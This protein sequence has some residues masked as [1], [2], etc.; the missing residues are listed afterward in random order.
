MLR[1]NCEISIY[2]VPE[3]STSVEKIII[4]N[5]HSV[6]IKGDGDTLADTCEI[7]MP[8]RTLWIRENNC[9]IHRGDKVEIYLGYNDIKEKR[10]VGWVKDVTAGIPTIIKC[11]DDV[12][13]LRSTTIKKKLYTNT[14]INKIIEDI[15]PAGIRVKFGGEMKIA[16]W[17][18][19]A[20]TV[21]GEIEELAE[22]FPIKAFF[23]LDDDGEPT[24]FVHTVMT[25]GRRNAGTFEEAKNII[26]HNLEYRRAEDVKIRIKGVS[27]QANGKTIEYSEGDGQEITKNYYNL[28]MEELKA[29]VKKEIKAEKWSGLNGTFE[30]F[31]RPMVRKGDTVDLKIEGTQKARYVVKGVTVSFGTGGYRQELETSRKIYYYE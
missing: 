18:T 23:A 16:S 24:L 17:R 10:F 1:L 21:A 12:F 6:K 14:T 29:M 15:L 7:E 22:S 25:D 5:V 4:R 20:T 26:S 9:P 8:K 30:T 27:R 28:T 13:V 2:H 31:G 19:T 11:E 3:G